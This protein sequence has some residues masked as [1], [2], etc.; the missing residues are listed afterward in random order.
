[1]RTATRALTQS[2]HAEASR[3]ARALGQPGITSFGVRPEIVD[4]VTDR[5][6]HRCTGDAALIVTTDP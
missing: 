1:M 6:R 4:G 3:V 5:S 2:A